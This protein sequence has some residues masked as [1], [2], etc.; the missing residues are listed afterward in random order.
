MNIER[1]LLIANIESI[2]SGLGFLLTLIRIKERSIY[3]KLVG[4]TL[5]L[6]FLS[7]WAAGLLHEKK[8]NPNYSSSVYYILLLP[9]VSLIYYYAFGKNHKNIFLTVTILSFLLT[10]LNLLF[11]QKSDINSYSFILQSIIIIAYTLFYFFHLLKELPTM[12]LQG[13]PMFWIN[14]AYIIFHSGALL[15]YV[16]S[17]YLVNELNNNL[18]VYW[19]FHNVL[20]IL[21]VVMLLVAIIL[22]L[23]NTFQGKTVS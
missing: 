15:L 16:F 8:I 18:L 10:T 21:E 9:I 23:R 19:T 17:S 11:F 1:F 3:I 4:I 2:L 13:L 12:N 20:S 14:S 5:F 7:H 6:S 22:D